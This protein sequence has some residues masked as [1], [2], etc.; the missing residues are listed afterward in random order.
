MTETSQP[1]LRRVWY[2]T[3]A[4]LVIDFYMTLTP[5]LWAFFKTH[6]SLSVA[7]FSYL[8][9]AIVF[10]GSIT[11]PF[12]GYFSDGRNRMAL[13][14]LGVLICGIFVSCIGFAPSAYFLA[15][16]LICAAFGSSL[17]HPTAGGLVTALAPGRANLAMA[18]FLT[19]GTLGM[20]FASIAGTQIVERYGL[21]YLWIIAIPA[22]ILA[23]FIYF[24]SRQM[25]LGEHNTNA[26]K[27]DFSVLRAAET[28][29]LWTLYF[30]SVFRS[31]IHTGFVSF[32]AIL[33]ASRGWGTGKIGWVFSGY[34]LSSTIGR[35]AGGYLADRMSQRKLLAFSCGSSAIFHAAFCLTDG[36]LSISLLWFAG[37]L[38]DLG[39]TTNIALAQRYLPRNT[40]TATGLMMGFSWSVAGVAML[41]VGRVAEWTS[42]ATALTG[43]SLF[44]IPAAILVA[45]LPSESQRASAAATD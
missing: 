42:T 12:M 11:Q 13:I 36:I 34:L 27:I 6:F 39:I 21:D 7:Q 4:H 9:S 44:L 24:Q 38:F 28:R 41:G 37:F 17:F 35:M 30:I 23:P 2:V 20:T 33:G 31:L 18:I 8:P 14:A 15:L 10:C 3:G 45:F 5:P 25:S 22:L 32:T 26:G 16:F 19:G 1:S 40:S 43:V 29:P